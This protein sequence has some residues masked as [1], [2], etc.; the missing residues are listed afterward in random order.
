VARKP[1]TIPDQEGPGYTR[2]YRVKRGWTWAHF[3]GNHKPD[4]G[5]REIFKVGP[6][7]ETDAVRRARRSIKRARVTLKAAPVKV[8]WPT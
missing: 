2:I 8:K 5:A 6:A 4:Y 3:G 1:K 7:G